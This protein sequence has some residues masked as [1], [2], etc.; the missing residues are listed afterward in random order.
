MENKQPI[1]DPFHT[2]QP[3]PAGHR[4]EIPPSLY[5]LLEEKE[6]KQLEDSKLFDRHSLVVLEHKML[7]EKLSFQD[8]YKFVLN[9]MQSKK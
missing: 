7:D 5:H 4:Y 1:A 9:S 2:P 8:A 6:I 3:L